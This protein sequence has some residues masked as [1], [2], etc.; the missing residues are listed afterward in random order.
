MPPL[1]KDCVD[2]IA[3]GAIDQKDRDCPAAPVPPRT[4]DV[5]VGMVFN[6]EIYALFKK[7]SVMFQSGL[8]GPQDHLNGI[9]SYKAT[10]KEIDPTPLLRDPTGE[11]LNEGTKAA[12]PLFVKEV[13]A[14]PTTGTLVWR[15]TIWTTGKRTRNAPLSY[16]IVCVFDYLSPR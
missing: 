12:F 10:L 5:A 6:Q 13:A 4:T 16:A 15:K 2:Q 3:G 1:V 8:I 7:Y 14:S 9:L 11:T